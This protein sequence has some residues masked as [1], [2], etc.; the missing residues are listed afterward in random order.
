M[1]G[2]GEG[3]EG[4]INEKGRGGGSDERRGGGRTDEGGGSRGGGVRGGLVW[5]T[6]AVNL[7]S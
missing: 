3:D 7:S 4:R 2:W 6:L 1:D 5:L